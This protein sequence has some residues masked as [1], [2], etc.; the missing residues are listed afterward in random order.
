MGTLPRQGFEIGHV[1]S[2]TFPIWARN[3]VLFSVISLIIY[4]P[5]VVY[6]VAALL[7]VADTKDPKSV[8]TLTNVIAIVGI[9]LQFILTGSVIYGVFRQL[10][11]Q[12]AGIGDCLRV[13]FAR[14]LSVLVV[15]ILFIV[16]VAF[17]PAF[18]IGIAVASHG[19]FLM[20]LVLPAI[21]LS[22]ILYCAYW[23]A[24]PVTVVERPGVF[25]S[26]RRSAELT[27]G[28]RAA[29]FVILLVVFATQGFASFVVALFTLSAGPTA[30]LFGNLIIS[31]LGG[32][33]VAVANAVTYHDLRVARDGIG[34]N[35]LISVFA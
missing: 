23:P 8:Q 35:D 26:F 5:L 4:S 24:V 29:I 19:V 31:I 1:I 30:A 7:W 17:A 10:Q 13:G 11:G 22:V 9:P 32:S 12:K 2:R 18:V 28:K 3:I 15:S 27:R 21:V 14:L 34:I 16:L 20:L 25:P 6:A 33:L